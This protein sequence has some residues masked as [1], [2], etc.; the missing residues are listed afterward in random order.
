M[1]V[2]LQP[3]VALVHDYLK[4]YGGAER[5]LE[6]LHKIWPD[7]PVYTAYFDPKALGIHARNFK[8]WNIKTSWL[9][10]LPFSGK[11]ISPLR[12]IAA[13]IFESL[14]LSEFDVVIS[15]C[16][17]YF[18]K[19]IK[20]KPGAKHLSYIHTPP[21]YL[22]GYTTSFNYK[23]RWWTRVVAE[24]MNHFLRIV[25]FEVSQRPDILIANS[26]NVAQRIE[27]FYRRESE[28]VYPPV[29]VETLIKSKKQKGKYFLTLNRL[30]RGKGTEVAVAACSKLDL[31]LKV[32]GTGSEMSNLKKIAGKSV[33]F[34]G[35]ITE[36]EKAEIFSET[37]ALIA[38]SEDEDFG[39]TV[40]E[41]QAAGAPVIAAK[42]GGHLETVIPGKTGE[43]YDPG[44]LSDYNSYVDPVSVENLAT[45][46]KN[47]NPLKYKQD[48]LRRNAEKFSEENFKNRIIKLT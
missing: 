16:N 35:E 2:P 4:E 15:S 26:K 44:F 25:D 31:P 39:I 41:A 9:Q 42:A 10:Y 24:I 28:I 3:K 8:D 19:A 47:F 14:D 32:A 23:K 33:Q 22:Y 12:I 38:C 37:I 45:V 29:N 13:N 6:S 48:D 18:S 40:V 27:K 34:L 43:F 17:T 1:K 11:L 7:A 46:L 5:V 36:E 30:S 21:R 20:V